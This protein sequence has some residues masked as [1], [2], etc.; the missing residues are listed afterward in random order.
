MVF[1]FWAL[2]ILR[3]GICLGSPKEWH[4]FAKLSRNSFQDTSI[5]LA[6]TTSSSV[7][8]TYN[9]VKEKI[10]QL[11]TLCH[12]KAYKVKLIKTLISFVFRGKKKIFCWLSFISGSGFVPLSLDKPVFPL[13]RY[14][15]LSIISQDISLLIIV[16]H[17]IVLACLSLCKLFSA[18]PSKEKDCERWC[19]YHPACSVPAASVK[20]RMTVREHW[21]W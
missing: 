6:R 20:M 16:I 10:R 1:F 3:G 14:F 21:W 12:K 19:P 18:C 9:R 5:L 2:P 17:A 13:L 15:P 11:L 4:F 7:S 8:N